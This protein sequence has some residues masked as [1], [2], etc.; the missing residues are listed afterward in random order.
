M[1]NK[2]MFS[3]FIFF[4][5]LLIGAGASVS[6]QVIDGV[7]AVVGGSP[8]LQSEVDSRRKQAKM[9]SVAFNQC[10]AL[11]DMLY[12]KLLFAQALKD[13]VEVTSEQ[14][15]EEL[16]RRMRHWITQFGS[17]QSFETFIGKNVENF[18]EESREELREV[19][20]VQKMQAKISE[21]VTVSPLEVKEFFDA[22]PKDSIPLV[23]AEI[24]VGH[25][26][27]KPAINSELK[28]Y[29]KEKIE[30]IRQDII[31]AKK[32]F[33]TSAII[34]SV[35]PGSAPNGGLYKNVP[36]GTFVAE[37]DAVAFRA[38]EKD[39]SEV[40]ET[41]Y[42]YHILMVESIRGEEIDVRH[43]LI[44]PQPSPED[45]LKAKS[46]LDSIAVLV[47]K[48][49]ISLSEAS[50]RFSDDE[51]TKLN[52]GLIAN[53]YTGSTK[54]EMD[55]LSQIDPNLVFT[56]DKLKTGETSAPSI[57][58][59]RD[60]KQAYH[61]I[62]VKSRTE[63]HRANLKEDYQRIQDQALAK[64]KQILVH[65]WIQKKLTSTYVRLT[66]EYKNCK[67]NNTWIN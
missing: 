21:G 33:A 20:L 56:I 22:I 23:N 27:K 11:E 12:Q 67:F 1:N 13:S 30:T 5:F 49:S 38:K 35:D 3:G 2:N 4:L 26:V 46:F 32:D 52:G 14:V 63:P 40:F 16:E 15:E 55:Q 18:K 9:D 25:I 58:Q 6:A 39:I 41:D 64:K 60:G 48:D 17:V 57:T 54:F 29:A 36:R 31:S 62:Y 61:I 28:K 37:F 10:V 42:G 47:M 45:L 34:H 53:P 24:E 65:N 59:T 50:S 51:E 44:T 66:E 43:I 8:I 19:L 7:I